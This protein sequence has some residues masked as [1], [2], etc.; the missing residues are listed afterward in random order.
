MQKA[1]F[2][3]TQF[4]ILLFLYPKFQA[5]VAAQAGLSYLIR[6]DKDRISQSSYCKPIY[7]PEKEKLV[8]INYCENVHTGILYIVLT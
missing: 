4:K 2:L 8:K 7:F 3:M 5:S 1:G 6:N